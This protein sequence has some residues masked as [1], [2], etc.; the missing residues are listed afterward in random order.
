MFYNFLDF[1][2]VVLPFIVG[3]V[4]VQMSASLSKRQKWVLIGFGVLVSVLTYLS[5]ANAR[6]QH[7]SELSKQGIAVDELK[8][9]L[10]GARVESAGKFG[11]MQGT[12]DAIAKFE[13]QYLSLGRGKDSQLDPSAKSY[14][15]MAQAI[16]KIAQNGQNPLSGKTDAME[17]A[18]AR[19]VAAR[20]MSLWMQ[21]E[22]DEDS[23]SYIPPGLSEEDRNRYT[24][25]RTKKVNKIRADYV[26]NLSALMPEANLYRIDILRRLQGSRVETTEDRMWEAAFHQEPIDYDRF[27]AKAAGMYLLNIAETL[28]PKVSK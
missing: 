12:L 1:L 27:N 23:A 7:D 8:S 10:Q 28:S 25:E 16:L 17:S 21:K 20:M 24:Q 9:E 18:E 6:K 26:N 3:L 2:V 14:D 15:A 19:D 22:R 11:Y 4:G 5:Q 13:S